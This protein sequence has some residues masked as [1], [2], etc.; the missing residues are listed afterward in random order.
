MTKFH[1]EF[2]YC[3]HLSKTWPHGG[4]PNQIGGGVRKKVGGVNSPWRGCRKIPVCVKDSDIYNN[5]FYYPPHTQT[6]HTPTETDSSLLAKSTDC[7]RSVVGQNNAISTHQSLT[8]NSTCA[9]VCA[10]KCYSSK[11]RGAKLTRKTSHHNPTVKANATPTRNQRETTTLYVSVATTAT[12]HHATPS[13]LQGA[14]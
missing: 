5:V 13:R 9:R 7:M 4:L 3:V 8:D 1:A 11:A 14:A 10:C 6:Q 12:C 2:P